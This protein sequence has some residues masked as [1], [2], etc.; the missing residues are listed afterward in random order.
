M[1]NAPINKHSKK[2]G[3]DQESILSSNTPDPGYQCERTTS[4][5]DNTNESQEVTP[6]PAGDPKASTNSRARKNNKTR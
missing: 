1:H 3:K 6:F 4:Q 2:E 5:L